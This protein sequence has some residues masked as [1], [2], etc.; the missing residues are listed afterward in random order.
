MR[1]FVNAK[2]RS[3]S[4]HPRIITA[5]YRVVTKAEATSD[6]VA[7]P[8]PLQPTKSFSELAARAYGK[9][10]DSGGDTRV[11]AVA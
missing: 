3:R 7:K 5:A 10:R 2:S 9:A 4:T 6:P 11:N 8:A 1:R